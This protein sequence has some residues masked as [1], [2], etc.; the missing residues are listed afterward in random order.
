GA[1][2]ALASGG[3]APLQYAWSDPALPNQA[4]VQ[5]LSS[6][7]YT[8]T[9]SDSRGCSL[10]KSIALSQPAP[11]VATVQSSP[12]PCGGTGQGQA[13]VSASGGIGPYKF[14]WANG[15]SGAVAAN[16]NAGT[17]TVT[18]ADALGCTGTAVALVSPPAPI[19]LALLSATPACA[20]QSNGAAQVS[21]SGGNGA[22]SFTWNDPLKQTAATA[23]QL[24]PGSYAVTVTDALGCSGTLS[25]TIPVSEAPVFK[26]DTQPV[27]CEGLDDG[28]LLAGVLAGNGPYQYVWNT[29]AAGP[30]INGLAPGQYRLT[31]TDGRGCTVQQTAVLEQGPALPVSIISQASPNCHNGADGFLHLRVTG[32]V[33]P[34]A[35][36][37][38][39]PLQHL[40]DALATQ[41]S[42]GTYI[43]TATDARG[44]KGTV[45]A[46][47]SNPP[48]PVFKFSV[49]PVSCFGLKNGAVAGIVQGVNQPIQY[50]W[51][52]GET[53]AG[54]ENLTAG[55][56]ALSVTDAAGCVYVDSVQVPQP[57]TPLQGTAVGVNP[58]CFGA[59]TGSIKIT[60]SG[61]AP[62]YRYRLG[63]GNWNGASVQLQTPAGWHTPAILDQNGCTLSLA[64]V[65]IR[66][67]LPILLEFDTVAPIALGESVQLQALVRQA[68]EPVSFFWDAA[69]SSWLSCLHCF[70]PLVAG[71]EFSHWFDLNVVDAGGCR[72]NGRI[73]VLVEKKRKVFVPTGFSPNGD[74]VND[75]LLAHGQYATKALAFKVFDRWGNLVFES[76]NFYLN[77]PNAGWDGTH[78]GQEAAP[79]V[80]VWVLE[81]EFADGLRDYYRGNTTLLR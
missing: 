37:W 22:L 19:S 5:S 4:T 56:Y 13:T 24:P 45:A 68:Q 28:A 25:V 49:S 9:I 78:R 62:P 32:G 47:L 18:V 76:G 69:D 6:G 2:T 80:Y 61:G 23:T 71:L 66:E 31:V 38:P 33:A 43:V 48:L 57:D 30:M 72:A 65:E 55:W 77:D 58:N 1:L 75:R 29:G 7:K 81:V 3:A 15:Q 42:A 21:V 73:Q 39:A 64:P 74:G 46:N 17:Y 44:C 14:S 34:Y 16:L 40:T 35:F 53:G 63:A 36:A 52:T 67:P 41:L 50:R 59:T 10:E 20:G 79:G 54:I 8:I 70:D 51:S 12:A 26:I 60:A 11:L 27:S